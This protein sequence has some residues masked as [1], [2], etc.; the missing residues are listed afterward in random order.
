MKFFNDFHYNFW[1]QFFHDNEVVAGKN[2][3]KKFK[4]FKS[5]MWLNF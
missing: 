1:E 3:K 4:I 5:S 2:V